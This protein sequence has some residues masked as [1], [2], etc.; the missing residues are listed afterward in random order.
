MPRKSD[1]GEKILAFIR[2]F[3]EQNGYYPTTR[4][5]QKGCSFTS[6]SVVDFHLKRL[7]SAG[8]IERTKKKS[9]LMRIAG[10]DTV[11]SP[12]V[13]LLGCIAAGHPSPYSLT[14]R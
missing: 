14:N 10:D 3:R 9:R 6:S 12:T 5:I 4:E 8:L 7:E 11:K 2:A 13:P 1:K